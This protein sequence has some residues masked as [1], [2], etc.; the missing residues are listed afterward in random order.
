MAPGTLGTPGTQGLLGDTSLQFRHVV[1]LFRL[2]TEGELVR[3]LFLK[4][5]DSAPKEPPAPSPLSLLDE[6]LPDFLRASTNRAPNLFF[7]ATG[8]VVYYTAGVGVL[9]DPER[10]VPVHVSG[11]KPKRR[12]GSRRRGRPI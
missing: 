3:A 8:E 10:A 2:A 12:Q 4:Y 6:L 1:M 9:L 5:L 7:V 11:S